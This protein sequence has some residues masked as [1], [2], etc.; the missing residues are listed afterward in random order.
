MPEPQQ[1]RALQ[2]AT[3]QRG[4]GGSPVAS[5]G[6]RR[7]AARGSSSGGSAARSAG[8]RPARSWPRSH[9]TS[10]SRPE[11]C[12]RG[13]GLLLASPTWQLGVAGVSATPFT[14]VF[15][16]V[17]V[18]VLD[19]GALLSPGLP[20]GP[21]QGISGLGLLL[22]GALPPPARARAPSDRRPPA[23][24]LA[25]AG[26][27]G[28]IAVAGNLWVMVWEPT[29]SSPR[30]RSGRQHRRRAAAVDR[31][32]ARLPR[33]RRRGM[34][35]WLMSLDGL[36]AGGAVLII[37]LC[38]STP[39]A[40]RRHRQRGRPGHDAALP[41]ARHGAGN[42]GGA[43]VLRTRGPDRPVLAL[44]SAGFVT[45]A[46][47]D[48]AFA[49]LAAQDRFHFGTPLDLGWIAGYLII[50]LAAWYPSDLS[51]AP[52]QAADGGASDARGTM[53]V[54]SV[55][56][57][58]AGVV[59]VPSARGDGSRAP[60][61]AAVA[62]ADPRGRRAAGC[63]WPADNAALRRGLE[64][65]VSDQTADLRRLAR[66]T[67]GAAHLGRR[68]HLR[69]RPRRAGHLRQPVRPPARWATR[70]HD[71]LGRERPRPLPRP[72]RGR[73]A[74]PV[75]GLLRHRRDPQRG[76]RHR[77]GGRLRA[78]RRDAPSRSRSPPRPLRRR[79]PRSA[80]PSWSSAT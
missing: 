13:V 63:C 1:R 10:M 42:G 66:Q 4:P 40:G 51:D 19:F 20:L 78:G 26:L 46:V 44:V 54:F 53:V 75:G 43:A 3:G 36:V 77:R 64:R 45:Y 41:A 21:R 68:R 30:A 73:P 59:Q 31:R 17:V 25:V 5:T 56:L 27:R 9:T 7:P 38:S 39:A 23:P 70:P 28:A 69:R 47:A 14:V 32:A 34:T 67:R 79:R 65:R 72:R 76:A 18:L 57:L 52:V 50:G 16:A 62:G 24:V 35:S 22:A 2:R 11:A 55:L 74:V 8:R 71:L 15:P 48:L 58:A 29:R 80:A 60:E 61:A 49:V 37:R 6:G 33:R 12:P